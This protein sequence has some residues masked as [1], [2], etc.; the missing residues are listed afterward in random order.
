VDGSGWCTV[1]SIC[2]HHAVLAMMTIQQSGSEEYNAGILITG[3]ANT[4]T[5][6]RIQNNF[7]GLVLTQG[8][9]ENTIANNIIR[10]N[11]WNGISLKCN[12]KGNHLTENTIMNN[13][14]AGLYVTESSY[15]SL[16][17][18]TIEDNTHTAYDDSDNLWDDGYPSGG[19]HWDDYQGVDENQDGIGDTAYSIP[20]GISTD[21]YPLMEPYTDEDV[22]PPDVSIL[23]PQNGLYIKNLQLF[24][25]VLKQKTI[26]LGDPTILIQASDARSGIQKVEI[27]IDDHVTPKATLYQPP[28]QW[29]WTERS[30]IKHQHVIIVVAYDNA[31]NAEADM[32][33]VKKFF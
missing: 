30:L 11:A 33:V 3:N 26:I 9:E 2:A 25:K 28:Y 15:N 4:I 10:D 21:R 5:Q 8:A 6:T 13:G 7:Q 1:V 18:N 23:S 12:S 17:H 24:S 32:T 29:T 22:V 31:G 27:Y 14:Y 16:Y 20:D 19:N